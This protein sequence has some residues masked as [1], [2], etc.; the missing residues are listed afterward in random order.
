MNQ[1]EKSFCT[2]FQKDSIDTNQTIMIELPPVSLAQNK[3]FLK[4]LKIRKYEEQ[5]IWIEGEENFIMNLAMLS[6]AI[7]GVML[8]IGMLLRAKIPFIGKMLIPASVIGGIIGVYFYEC[9]RTV[10]PLN[11]DCGTFGDLVD[12]M[13]VLSFISIGLTG[14][15][16]AKKEKEPD[17]T[18]QTGPVLGGVGDGDHLVPF[19]RINSCARG[20]PDIYNRKSSRMSGWYGILIPFG[21][22]QGP[23]QA[24]TYGRLFEN[25]Y[26]F[27]NAEM[28][29][30]TLL[31]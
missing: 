4:F 18:K 29:A 24:S 17:G 30:L 26:G 19:I 3:I 15:Q 6:L 13:F 25:V 1:I 10:T 20:N 12:T 11:L 5:Y 14:S 7:I 27:E 9:D 16:K 8:C 2:F 28:V 21:F 31:L 23:G 22:C